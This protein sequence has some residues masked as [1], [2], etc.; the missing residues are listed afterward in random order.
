MTHRPRKRKAE[1][2]EDVVVGEED[3]VVEEEGGGHV[4][5]AEE[6]VVVSLPNFL[7]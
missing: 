2:T 6:G 5:G 3:G 1:A 4:E 7:S